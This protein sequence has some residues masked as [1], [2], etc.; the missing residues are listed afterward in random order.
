MRTSALVF[1]ALIW[2]TAP[3]IASPGPPESKDSQQYIVMLTD[4]RWILARP[5]EMVT[6]YWCSTFIIR[7]SSSYL[8]QG[9]RGVQQVTK[10]TVNGKRQNAGVL[11]NIN[12]LLA[13]SGRSLE[14]QPLCNTSRVSL[15]LSSLQF[16]DPKVPTVELDAPRKSNR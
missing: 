8:L 6:E 10:I 2:Q 14:I 11:A 16:G 13:Q 15:M 7:I 9:F 4:P 3:V 1:A 5:Q 12:T